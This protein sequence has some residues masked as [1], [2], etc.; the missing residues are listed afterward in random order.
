MERFW[1]RSDLEDINLSEGTKS[2]ATPAASFYVADIESRLRVALDSVNVR[3]APLTEPGPFSLSR[4]E[5]T[6]MCGPKVTN[7]N[8]PTTAA[9][10]LNGTQEKTYGGKLSVTVWPNPSRDLFTLS[11]HTTS[12]EPFRLRV[13]D[14]MGNLAETRNGIGASTTFQIGVNFYHG[15]YMVEVMQGEKRQ[16]LKLIRQ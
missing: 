16:I 7:Q 15:I 5:G 8:I 12:H 13:L 14:A 2:L 3:L 4:S 11:I 1:K 9:R 10:D 6:P